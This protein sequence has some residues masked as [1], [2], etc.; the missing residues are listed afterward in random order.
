MCWKI[1]CFSLFKCHHLILGAQT[2]L[3]LFALLLILTTITNNLCWVI[4]LSPCKISKFKQIF[5]SDFLIRKKFIWEHDIPFLYVIRCFFLFL[6]HVLAI[7]RSEAEK[8][9]RMDLPSTFIS[10]SPYHSCTP[11]KLLESLPKCPFRSPIWKIS[12]PCAISLIK[13]SKS[14]QNFTLRCFSDPI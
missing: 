13:L 12:F 10:Q 5:L 2:C 8:S 3:L 7:V 11:W 9:S 14:S 6:K 1:L 4:K